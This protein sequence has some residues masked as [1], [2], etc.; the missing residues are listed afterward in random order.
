[1]SRSTP[2]R[3][4]HLRARVE[5]FTA[6]ARQVKPGFEPGAEVDAIC[7][8]LDRLPLALELAATRVKF[9]SERQL[10][11][12]LE[13]RLP[14]LAGGRRDLPARQ[15]TMRAAIAWSYDLLSEPEQR[16]FA[17]LAVFVGSFELEAAERDL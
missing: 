9:L 5:L 6:R 7:A 12:R 15:A 13:Q 2:F 10:L 14:L 3:R 1:M 8:R 17:R 16:L 4:Y 11:A